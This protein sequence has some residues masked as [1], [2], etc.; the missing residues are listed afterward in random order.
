MMFWE[1]AVG[2]VAPEGAAFAVMAVEQ[3]GGQAV[4]VDDVTVSQSGGILVEEKHLYPFGQELIS[5]GYTDGTH[6][7]YRYGYQGQYAE[8]DL[9]TGWDNFELR[10]YDSR[11][12]RWTAPDPY[13]Q[14]H[15]PYVGMGN[16]PVN[17]VDPDGG[18]SYIL[19]AKAAVV[20]ALVGGA[21]GYLLSDGDLNWTIAGFVGG[22]IIGGISYS[23]WAN[24]SKLTTR[25][26]RS[27]LTGKKLPTPYTTPGKKVDVTVY[28]RL[29]STLEMS[30]LASVNIGGH[31]F[32][33][34]GFSSAALPNG[35][36]SNINYLNIG[37][38]SLPNITGPLGSIGLTYMSLLDNYRQRVNFKNGRAFVSIYPDVN[39]MQATVDEL[40]RVYSG[41]IEGT[42]VTAIELTMTYKVNRWRL[43][44]WSRDMRKMGWTVYR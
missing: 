25:H 21:A 36:I 13:G 9:E 33:I 43:S 14:Y 23:P 16:D 26:T 22:G 7:A 2:G 35:R 12:G 1:V 5:M 17:Q 4:Y 10:M 8:K 27:Q 40:S 28:R 6:Y 32:N 41:K 39:A 3:E 44:K 38:R 24:G 15:S 34:F 31:I 19:N 11:I 29:S 37:V 30:D 18:L 42:N 20:G